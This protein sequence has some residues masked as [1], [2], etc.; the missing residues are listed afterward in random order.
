MLHYITS[1]APSARKFFGLISLLWLI[2]VLFFDLSLISWI[3]FL[4]SLATIYLYQQPRREL[5][6]FDN[7]S[8]VS[9]VDGKVTSIKKKYIGEHLWYEIDVENTIFDQGNITPMLNQLKITHVERT[10]GIKVPTNSL[11]K[12]QLSE[13]I[14][15][16]Y[17][18]GNLILKTIH[19]PSF[20]SFFSKFDILK[21]FM[22]N[23]NSLIGFMRFGS[24]KI[25][26]PVD[27]QLSIDE[28]THIYSDKT[29]LGYLNQ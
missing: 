27:V 24:T 10:H 29:V 15:V 18:K 23:R 7:N 13:Q 20:C 25:Y 9:P 21:N 3:L 22:L 17:Q 12:N 16:E 6:H 4:V 1:I 28:N 19:Y 2:S 14:E 26:I 11:K 8:L 5:K